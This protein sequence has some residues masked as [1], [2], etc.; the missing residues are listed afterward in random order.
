MLDGDG[1][2]Q[3]IS[4]DGVLSPLQERKLQMAL[5]I[6]KAVKESRMSGW[7]GVKPREQGIKAALFD[8]LHDEAEVERMFRIIYQQTE[9]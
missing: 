9:Y 1:K 5:M 4:D 2:E 8:F 6:D 3:V 7:R